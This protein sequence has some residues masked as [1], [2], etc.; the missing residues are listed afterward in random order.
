MNLFAYGTLMFPEVW[1]RVVGRSFRTEAAVLADY[2]AWQVRGGLFPVLVAAAGDVTH[3]LVYFNLDPTAFIRLDDHE[4]DFYERRPVEVALASGELVACQ[5]YILPSRNSALASTAR[6][7][8]ET[9]RRESL[10]QY[11]R[12]TDFSGPDDAA[13]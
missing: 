9:F 2:A 5:A 3:G 7:D 8:A 10:A 11:L 4:S 12:T 1:E 13:L 6:W